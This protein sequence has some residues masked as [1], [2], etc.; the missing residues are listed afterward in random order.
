MLA[1]QE[2]TE[3][4]NVKSGGGVKEGLYN[5]AIRR[6]HKSGVYPMFSGARIS[7]VQLRIACHA[8][9]A[10]IQD[11]GHNSGLVRKLTYF[12]LYAGQQHH[13]KGYLYISD[14]EQ[15]GATSLETVRRLRK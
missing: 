2:W 8:P 5:S 3:I 11:G 13:F 9:T 14:V 1:L 6:V 4:C 7:M 10:G 12:W 15:H